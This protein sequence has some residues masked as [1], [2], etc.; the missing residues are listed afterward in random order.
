MERGLQISPHGQRFL[1]SGP[2]L[3]KHSVI[4]GVCSVEIELRAV[5]PVLTTLIRP[6][7]ALEQRSTAP[8]RAQ[9]PGSACSCCGQPR[10]RRLGASRSPTQGYSSQEE[11]EETSQKPL[12]SFHR[13]FYHP[14]T[15]PSE[16]GNRDKE[17]SPMGWNG[18][19]F[20]RIIIKTLI[21]ILLV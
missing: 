17:R 1:K 12:A 6:T 4:S 9:S 21:V 10:C 3:E 8:A 16:V 11:E 20:N 14:M 13:L 15:P 18:S 2:P 7:A 5:S 19:R